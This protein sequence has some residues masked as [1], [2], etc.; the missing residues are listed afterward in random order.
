[1]QRFESDQKFYKCSSSSDSSSSS[2]SGS[3][4]SFGSQELKK[5]KRGTRSHKKGLRTIVSQ[6][7]EGFES[8]ALDLDAGVE[9]EAH[10]TTRVV[11]QFSSARDEKVFSDLTKAGSLFSSLAYSRARIES[12]KAE[13]ADARELLEANGIKNSIR[14]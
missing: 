3:E 5:S 7:D 8:G 6:D 1:M 12:L 13:L 10:S 11:G 9:L 14:I 2:E 4:K